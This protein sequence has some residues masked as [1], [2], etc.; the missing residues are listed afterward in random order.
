MLW[1]VY[2]IAWVFLFFFYHYCDVCQVEDCKSFNTCGKLLQHSIT[3]NTFEITGVSDKNCEC[4]FFENGLVLPHEVK[5]ITQDA[6]WGPALNSHPTGTVL[7]SYSHF[8]KK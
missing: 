4:M 6:P 2:G 7:R 3:V 8:L 5:V 1:S